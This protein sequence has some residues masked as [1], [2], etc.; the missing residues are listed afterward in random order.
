MNIILNTTGIIYF[1]FFFINCSIAQIK[2][3][4]N[5]FYVASWNIENL[6][7]TFNNPETNDEDFLPEGDNRWTED[8]F[9]HKLGNLAKVINYM[10]DGCGPDVIGLLEVENINVIKWLIYKFKDRD[11]IIAHRDSPDQRGID[12]ALI[13]D[14]NVFGIVGIDTIRVNIPTGIP[15]R[16][17]LNVTLKFLR[18]NS[19][20][21]FFVNHWPSRRGGEA[22]SE[23]N[24]IA[25]AKTL[26]EYLEKLFNEDKNSRIILLG[27]FNDEPDNRSIFQILGA[28]DFDCDSLKNEVGLL[29]LSY[30]SKAK[31]EGSYLF[32][33]AWNMIDQIIISSSLKD[34]KD[35]EYICNSFSVIK[36]EFMVSK[37]DNGKNGPLPTYSGNR[38]I[39]GY[40]DHFP[41]GAK[42]I[43]LKEK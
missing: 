15:T 37:K 3:N 1:L 22:K 5:T 6:F 13:F 16:Y 2:E 26:R 43:L 40:S 14:R 35:I 4:D 29:N 9:Q 7:D 27:D 32:G 36:P 21:H 28:K 25:A 30:K 38:Y 20:I 10:N 31:G 12:A 41:V 11:Y 24:R 18:D 42:F 23:P 34:G 33:S 19:V 8:R 39:G 17:I